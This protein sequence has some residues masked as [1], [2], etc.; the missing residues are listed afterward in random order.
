MKQNRSTVFATY[1]AISIMVMVGC[2]KR[3]RIKLSLKDP[4]VSA[5]NSDYIAD[6]KKEADVYECDFSQVEGQN[7]LVSLSDAKIVLH[8]QAADSKKYIPHWFATRFSENKEDYSTFHISSQEEGII[9]AM[10]VD[11]TNRI[12]FNLNTLTGSHSVLKDQEFKASGI[13]FLNCKKI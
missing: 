2:D 9:S 13:N 12:I 5:H 6:L 7:G 10:T 11:G 4:E 8:F 3:E 1:L